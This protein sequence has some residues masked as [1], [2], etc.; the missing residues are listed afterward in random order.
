LGSTFSALV[1]GGFS[2]L[3]V[4]VLFSD[5]D[6]T[7]N[8]EFSLGNLTVLLLVVSVGDSL[9]DLGLIGDS[10]LVWDGHLGG[11][12]LGVG[13]SSLGGESGVVIISV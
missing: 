3:L 12:D 1:A 11:T 13:V 4:G 9:A 6:L 5:G 7:I 2:L 8:G 10:V